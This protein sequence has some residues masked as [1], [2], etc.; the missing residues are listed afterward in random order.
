ME[1]VIEKMEQADIPQVAELERQIFSMPWSEQSFE[2]MLRS[3]DTLYLVAKKDGILAGYCGFFQSFDEA[4]VMNVAVREEFRSQG[5]AYRMLSELMELGRR[6]GVLRYTLEVRAG[7]KAAVHLY[8]KLGFKSVGIR[9]GFYEKP[10]ED[11][12]IMW[13]DNNMTDASDYC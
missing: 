13:T 9:K 8:E 3:K 1:L 11:A 5:V 6:R 4:D 12:V 2:T 7:N 10:R